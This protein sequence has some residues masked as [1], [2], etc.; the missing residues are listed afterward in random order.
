MRVQKIFCL[1]PYCF[2]PAKTGG[3]KAI[4]AFYRLLSLQAEVVCIS[5]K[6]N[7]T[8][9]DETPYRLRRVL[10][11]SSLRY[12][13]IFYPFRLIR[14]IRR[15]NPSL[16]EME[17]PYFGWMM[18]PVKRITSKPLLVRSHNIEGLRFKTIGKWWWKIMWRYEKWVYQKAEH[19]FFITDEDRK[20]AIE[21][22]GVDQTKALTIPY[23]IEQTAAPSLAKKQIARRNLLVRHGLKE[24]DVLLL[25]NGA[26]D[27]LPNVEALREL[28]LH[29]NAFGKQ[30][31]RFKLIICGKDIPKDMIADKQNQ[32][33]IF[34]G[35]VPD[36]SEYFLGAGVF[37]NPV[38]TGGGIKTKLVEA[39]ANDLT[40]LSF[41]QGAIGIDPAWCNGKLIVVENYD[42]QSF[43]NF[44]EPA[45]EIRSSVGKAFFD[46]FSTASQLEKIKGIF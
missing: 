17:Q 46:H 3:Q 5:T 44:I 20:Y 27:Y 9:A 38:V 23:S 19:I 8:T 6:N 29:F 43:L 28:L 24:G 37:L 40:A 14:L 42:W 22:M 15:E 7:D 45:T 13:N 35:F 34:A 39:L 25:F 11:N 21:K 26:F 4:D 18:V 2:L 12:I 16:L 41:T 1:A 10:S 33:V 36:I 31:P 30:N 32:E